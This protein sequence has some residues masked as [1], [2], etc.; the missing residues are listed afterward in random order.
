VVLS[1]GSSLRTEKVFN[2]IPTLKQCGPLGFQFGDQILSDD[3]D[4]WPEKGCWLSPNNTPLQKLFIQRKSIGWE[5]PGVGKGSRLPPPC[6][7]LVAGRPPSPGCP[8]L[9]GRSRRHQRIPPILLSGIRARQ[10]TYIVVRGGGL[11]DRHPDPLKA[12]S[13]LTSN[14]LETDVLLFLLHTHPKSKQGFGVAVT[15]KGRGVIGGGGSL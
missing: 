10:D 1:R 7:L 2:H 8:P 12:V 3:K 9:Q 14:L 5:V 11:F 15:P 13:T 6:W 4:C